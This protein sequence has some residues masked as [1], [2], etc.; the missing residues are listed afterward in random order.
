MIHLIGVLLGASQGFNRGHEVYLGLE[1]F[2][3]ADFVGTARVVIIH[4]LDHMVASL[5]SVIASTHDSSLHA[6]AF[7]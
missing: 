3:I 2:F 4:F 7:D 5:G 6:R 1:E